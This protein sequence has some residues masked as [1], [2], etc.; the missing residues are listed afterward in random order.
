MAN[1]GKL[2]TDDD[3]ADIVGTIDQLSEPETIVVKAAE[4]MVDN[5]LDRILF[6]ATYTDEEYDIATEL[7]WA[8]VVRPVNRF[9]LLQYPVTTFTSLKAVNDRDKTT[10]AITAS[11]TL[12]KNEY[13]VKTLNGEITLYQTTFSSS[14]RLWPSLLNA[15]SLASFPGGTA[16]MIATYTAGY[17]DATVP[18]DL[19]FLILQLVARLHRLMKDNYFTVTAIESNFGMTTLMRSMFTPEERVILNSYKRPALA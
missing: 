7:A 6:K 19:K 1:A 3:V 13:H 5:A 14:D 4:S 16:R 10:G 18:F 2:V 15:N 17:T 12:N 8:G 9:R 11:T